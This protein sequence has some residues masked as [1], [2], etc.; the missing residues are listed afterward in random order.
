MQELSGMECLEGAKLSCGKC[1]GYKCLRETVREVKCPGICSTG[2][3]GL[4]W[5]GS[6]F[7]PWEKFV[8]ELRG[9]EMSEGNVWRQCLVRE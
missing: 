6:K 9:K 2:L 5:P 4:K 7:V 1:P 3:S 8:E